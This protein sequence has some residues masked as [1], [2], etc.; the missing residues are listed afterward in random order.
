ML[1]HPL[2]QVLA[3][4]PWVPP[5]FTQEFQNGSSP[6]FPFSAY[7]Y[8][9]INFSSKG[10]KAGIHHWAN[11]SVHLEA[12][13]SS[14]FCLRIC[15]S[16][17]VPS[18]TTL[19]NPQQVLIPY[20]KKLLHASITVTYRAILSVAEVYEKS[21]TSSSAN[22]GTKFFAIW[23]AKQSGL[24]ST[25]LAQ[26][27]PY[28]PRTNSSQLTLRCFFPSCATHLLRTF[29]ASL[30]TCVAIA[31]KIISQKCWGFTARG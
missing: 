28:E 24:P 9:S 2:N 21:G 29:S 13:K 1:I 19:G 25:T 20:E 11:S 15:Q 31:C 10:I 22:P 30:S 7:S 16:F 18:S 8:S 3:P 23:T 27:F 5:R 14:A 26:S 17:I 6:A 4:E 12:I